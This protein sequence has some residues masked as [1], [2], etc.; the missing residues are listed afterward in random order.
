[1]KNLNALQSVL[2]NI[3]GYDLET[4][5]SCSSAEINKLAMHGTLVIIPAILG[6]FTMGY[7]IY[8]FSDSVTTAVCS[9]GIWA[10]IILFLDRAILNAGKMESGLS[11]GMVGRFLLAIAIAFTVAEP[12]VLFVFKDSIGQALQKEQIRK[13]RELD[14]YYAPQFKSLDNQLEKS[15]TTVAAM[16]KVYTIE[17]DGKGSDRG[18]GKGPI[19]EQKFADFK[20]AKQEYVVLKGEVDAQKVVIKT[21]YNRDLVNTNASLANGFAGRLDVLHKIDSPAIINGSW[22]I[23]ALFFFIELIPFLIKLQKKSS[24]GYWDIVDISNDE[25]FANYEAGSEYRKEVFQKHE[26]MLNEDRLFQLEERMAEQ[27]VSHYRRKAK[28][29]ANYHAQA[30]ED[31]L[32]QTFRA[33][34]S[35]D[36]EGIPKNFQD[37]LDKIYNDLDI[38]MNAIMDDDN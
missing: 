21:N 15:V 27:R 17:M 37:S 30:L 26:K 22:A 3:A 1:M 18:V 2:I 29:M 32:N 8:L 14:S 20:K 31:K 23:R 35:A 7:A 16:Q 4:V 36:Q 28:K 5:K 13:Q 33:A 6:F 11:V 10:I 25:V 12:A 34:K 9:G 38:Q 24:S 19:F